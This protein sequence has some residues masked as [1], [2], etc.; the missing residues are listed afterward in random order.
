ME[1]RK[2]RSRFPLGL[3][4]GVSCFVGIAVVSRLVGMKVDSIVSLLCLR[5]YMLV[6]T[7][8]RETEKRNKERL[9]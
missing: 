2:E 6:T 8:A 9:P 3:G 5:K 1:S 4:K 7:L